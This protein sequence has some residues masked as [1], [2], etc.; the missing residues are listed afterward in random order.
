[1]NSTNLLF[2]LYFWEISNA[3]KI[4]IIRHCDKP[5]NPKNPCCSDIGYE[6]SIGWANYFKHYLGNNINIIT[7]NFHSNTICVDNLN[8]SK[9]NCQKS[10]RMTLTTYYLSKELLNLN[11]KIQTINLNYCIGDSGKIF[12]HIQTMKYHNK[13]AIDII[14]I[15]EHHE[16][17]N[18]I[19]KYNVKINQWKRKL[20]KNYDIVFMIDTE[21]NKLYYA[22]YN[23]KKNNYKCSHHVIKWLDSFEPIEKYESNNSKQNILTP[24]LSSYYTQ[25]KMSNKISNLYRY[26]QQLFFIAIIIIS[27]C[28]IYFGI[29]LGKCITKYYYNRYEYIE[30]Q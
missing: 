12:H 7:S 17:V 16:I 9:N 30:I 15:W 4:W 25:L 22:C 5:N 6:R 3:N 10:Q 24:P 14:L 11:C 27:I 23:Y 28:G 21:K 20:K 18:F 13:N 1:M 26:K 29:F 19:R 8:H 2:F